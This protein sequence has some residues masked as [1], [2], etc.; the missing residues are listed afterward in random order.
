MVTPRPIS[1]AM[2]LNA[3]MVMFAANYT[4]MRRNAKFPIRSYVTQT[5]KYR[6]RSLLISQICESKY[7]KFPKSNYILL[8]RLYVIS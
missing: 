8:S 7:H 1:A 5:E 2:R 4:F 6:H 3:S